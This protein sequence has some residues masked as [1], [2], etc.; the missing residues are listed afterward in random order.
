M[1]VYRFSSSGL[2]LLQ[3]RLA[4]HRGRV[5]IAGPPS[6]VRMF[7]SHPA[8]GLDQ[9]GALAFSIAFAPISADILASIDIKGVGEVPIAKGKRP[10]AVQIQQAVEDSG[11]K[12]I[13]T[14]QMFQSL[15]RDSLVEMSQEVGEEEARVESTL[16]KF[17]NPRSGNLGN[18]FFKEGETGRVFT[19]SLFLEETARAT[20]MARAA[21]ILG[22]DED[23]A[24]MI[25]DTMTANIRKKI[26][27]VFQNSLNA[28]AFNTVVLGNRPIESISNSIAGIEG[29]IPISLQNARELSRQLEQSLRR[30]D[31]QPRGQR[32]TL[33]EP[34]ETPS[35]LGRTGR[36]PRV[37]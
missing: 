34:A 23:F 32:G 16:G 17:L 4:A 18:L 29:N 1:A 6:P 33:S 24:S 27:S 26:M 12:G 31:V 36:G 19:T 30:L 3:G 10:T 7:C 21:G 15:M 22:A 9:V 8:P 11:A 2:F 35:V 28:A 13:Y 14:A 25:L 37:N 5:A 20:E